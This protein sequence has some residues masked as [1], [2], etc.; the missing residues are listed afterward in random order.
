[1]PVITLPSAQVAAGVGHLPPVCPRHGDP[2]VEQRAIKLVSKPPAWAAIFILGG[3]IL[4]LIVALAVR[5]TV[6]APAW[7]WCATCG[8]QRKKLLAI[9][10]PV[11]A[12]GL[13]LLVGA[14]AMNSDAS[15][16]LALLGIVVLLVGTI[17]AA[18]GGVLPVTGAVVSGDGRYVEIKNGSDRFLMALHQGRARV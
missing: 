15:A 11:L 4:Y 7:P 2:A 8:A 14:V 1:M 12:A 17:V 16:V 13:L 5:K 18:R 10:L 9:G 3:G 6:K